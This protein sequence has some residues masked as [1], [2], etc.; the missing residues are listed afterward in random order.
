MLCSEFYILL[1]S[2][3]ESHISLTAGSLQVEL[4]LH[5]GRISEMEKEIILYFPLVIIL[6][7]T[8]YCVTLLDHEME[9]KV[10][11]WSPYF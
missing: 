8:V 9:V 11:N 10:F 6:I 7:Y 3:W 1:G 5:N 2:A 4:E